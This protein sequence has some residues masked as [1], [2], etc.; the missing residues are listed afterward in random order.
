MT[1]EWY[2]AIEGAFDEKV[3]EIL[4]ELS[5]DEAIRDTAASRTIRK[6]A[7]ELAALRWLR[8]SEQ[9]SWLDKWRPAGFRPPRSAGAG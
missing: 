5:A 8:S 6:Y 1:E 4:S 3:A 2:E 7:R 9:R